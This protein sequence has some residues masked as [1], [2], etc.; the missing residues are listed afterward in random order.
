M[1]FHF[2]GI[3]PFWYHFVAVLVC[4]RFGMWPFWMYTVQIQQQQPILLQR[5]Q[6]W[7]STGPVTVKRSQQKV[8]YSAYL[9]PATSRI[10]ELDRFRRRSQSSTSHRPQIDAI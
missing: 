10:T 3:W 6:Q 4:G 5:R 8:E 1:I 7:R 2:I 9:P